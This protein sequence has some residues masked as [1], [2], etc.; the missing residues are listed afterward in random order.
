MEELRKKFEEVGRVKD[1]FIPEKRDKRFGFVRFKGL[2]DEGRILEEINNLW[3]GSFII[4]ASRPRFERPILSRKVG[5]RENNI[6]QRA[7]ET[8]RKPNQ[9]RENEGISYSEVVR[10][11]SGRV[12]SEAGRGVQVSMGGK[13][14]EVIFQS[15]IDEEGWLEG[16]VVACLK[17]QFTWEE[18]GEEIQEECEGKLTV[19]NMG[20]NLVLIQD[21]NGNNTME[22]IK[23][24]EGWSEFWLEWRREWQYTDVNQ[25]SEVWTR[26]FGVPLQ[27]WTP[28]FFA[29]GCSSFG[30]L[31]ELHE[32][33]RNKLRL[34]EAFVKVSTGVWPI[35]RSL[36]CR[37]GGA[38]FRIRVEEIRCSGFMRGVH[39][40]V[41]VGS[42]SESEFSAPE[43]WSEKESVEAMWEERSSPKVGDE[44]SVGGGSVGDRFDAHDLLAAKVYVLGIDKAA[45]D[46]YEG[47]EFQNNVGIE[48]AMDMEG[49]GGPVD[50]LLELGGLGVGEEKVG[51]EI[52]N[53]VILSTAP[54]FLHTAPF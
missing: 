15:T 48:V 46:N 29:I 2:G 33:S 18:H 38:S 21:T 1:I 42:E 53:R 11:S 25:H 52:S 45:G 10:G 31:V 35:D 36:R 23:G 3:M 41:H 39:Q 24:F 43:E 12:S 22:V 20:G 28:R 9:E 37:I 50:G 49:C 4:R 14:D 40:Q 26:W 34:D 16:A 19:R 6:R 47:E 13:D 54:I 5:G 32:V 51:Q 30:R 7:G 17:A 27:A 44:P 8:I